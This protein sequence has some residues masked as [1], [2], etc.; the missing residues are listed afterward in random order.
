MSDT[1]YS[2]DVDCRSH[3]PLVSSRCFCLKVLFH[4]YPLFLT[5]LHFD[6]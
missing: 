3:Y 6:L 2:E 5:R 4:S 1:F